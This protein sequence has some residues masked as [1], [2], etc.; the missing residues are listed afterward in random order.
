MTARDALRL[1]RAETLQVIGC[2]EPAAIAY[3]IR[4]LTR[5]LFRKPNPDTLRLQLRVSSDAYRNASTAVVPK[6]KQPGVHAAAAAGI[7]SRSNCFNVFADVDLP[8]ARRFFRA[9]D[10]LDAAPV[11]KKGL[12]VHAKLDAQNEIVLAGRHNQIERFILRGRDRTPA[13]PNL[14]EPP[15]IPGIAALAN[16]RHAS[17]ERFALDFIRRQV[18][19]EK[20]HSLTDQVVRRI[21]GRMTGFSH[22]VMT[23]TGSGNQGIFIALPYLHLHKQYGDAI[24]PALVFTLLTQIMLSHRHQRLSV[25]CGLATKAAPAIAAGLAYANGAAPAQIQTLLQTLPRQIGAIP[26]DGA[27]PACGEKARRALNVLHIENFRLGVSP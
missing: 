14:P 9:P 3:A 25:R 12:F 27:E 8:A 1:L 16:A 23:F 18:P 20:N 7:A 15:G 19:P 13:A 22:P 11:R 10:W 4:T 24:L 26:C 2:T 6:L 21:V 17:L 5:P